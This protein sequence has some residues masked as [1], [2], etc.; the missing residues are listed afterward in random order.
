ML[1]QPPAESG[2]AAAKPTP[3]PGAER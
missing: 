2:Q 3:R 1:F